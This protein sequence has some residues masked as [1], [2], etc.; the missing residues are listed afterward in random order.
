V[1]LVWGKRLRGLDRK[2]E[3]LEDMIEG[4]VE[5]NSREDSDAR[6]RV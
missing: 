3:F 2:E 1:F 6:E 5:R 4:K